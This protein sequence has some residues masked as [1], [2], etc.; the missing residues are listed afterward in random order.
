[1]S[2]ASLLLTL[3]ELKD[4]IRTHTGSKISRSKYENEESKLNK[5]IYYEI[6]GKLDKL[7]DKYGIWLTD[8]NVDDENVMDSAKEQGFRRDSEKYCELLIWAALNAA[9][10]RAEDL[11]EKIKM[12]VIKQIEKI[13]TDTRQKYGAQIKKN[14]DMENRWEKEDE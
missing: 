1:M 6:I 8:V 3:L 4:P 7:A 13:E 12:K 5:K 14:I 11:P 10:L 9:L 2:K